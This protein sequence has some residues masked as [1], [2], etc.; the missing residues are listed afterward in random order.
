MIRIST[1]STQPPKNPAVM[2]TTEP[3]AIV[4]TVAA[5]PT[6]R[7]IREPHTNCSGDAATEVVGAERELTAR[8][9][10]HVGLSIDVDRR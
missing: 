8:R 6:N 1:A 4:S 3:M 7:L 9:L 10:A 5:K 2:P